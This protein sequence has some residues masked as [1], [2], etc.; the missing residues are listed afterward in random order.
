MQNF[1]RQDLEF[2]VGVDRKEILISPW[3]KFVAYH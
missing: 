1:A 2:A 3:K